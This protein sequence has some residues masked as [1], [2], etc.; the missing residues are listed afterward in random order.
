MNLA[1]LVISSLSLIAVII[2]GWRSI[3]LGQRA[4]KAAEVSAKASEAAAKATKESALA[5][6]RAAEA[7]ERSV[8][9]SER[10]AALADQDARC[11]R[12]EGVLDVILSM[13]EVFN[14]QVVTHEKDFPPWTPGLH[15]QEMLIR[16]ALRRKLEGRLVLFEEQLDSRTATRTLTT[17]NLWSSGLLETAIDEVKALLKAAANLS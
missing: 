7:T 10:A 15:S 6:E 12:I 14:E 8:R 11:R 2:I 9:A 1:S 16:T 13:R 3:R 17:P 5:S 4:A